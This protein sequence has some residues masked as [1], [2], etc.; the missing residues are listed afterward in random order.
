MLKV[1]TRDA[2]T[3]RHADKK[4]ESMFFDVSIPCE[5]TVTIHTAEG[6]MFQIIKN[7][8]GAFQVFRMAYGMVSNSRLVFTTSSLTNALEDVR[9]FNM[10]ETDEQP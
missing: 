8:A 4:G 1:C 9:V 5:N 10:L 6:T 3:A 2:L 7:D